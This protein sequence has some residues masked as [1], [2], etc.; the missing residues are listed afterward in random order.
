MVH[1]GGDP[2][3]ALDL[4]TRLRRGGIVAIQIDRAGGR[5]RSISVDFGDRHFAVPKGP[6]QL[7]T[8]TGAPLLPVFVRRQGYFEYEVE[9]R[10]AIHLG[11]KADPTEIQRAAA[12]AVGEMEDFLRRNATQWFHFS[13]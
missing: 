11:R 2:R 1:R 3:D 8:L 13:G 7:A 6:F 10:P 4:L 9:V 12:S 5:A